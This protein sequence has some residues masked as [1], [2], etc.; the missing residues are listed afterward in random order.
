VDGSVKRLGDE[1]DVYAID[2]ADVRLLVDAIFLGEGDLTCDD[3][4]DVNDD[5]LI[6]L[7]D[8][9]LL[10]NHLFRGGVPP[11]YPYPRPGFDANA[12]D[13]LECEK[14]LPLFRPLTGI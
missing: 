8:A 9:I 10:L 2:M 13:S 5:G 4:A 7:T 6:D 3:A 12:M 1:S 11:V 14:P